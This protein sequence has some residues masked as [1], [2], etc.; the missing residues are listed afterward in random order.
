[1]LYAFLRPLLFTLEPERAHRLALGLLRLL[2]VLS[3]QKPLSEKRLAQ[4]LWGLHFPNPVGLAAGLDKDAEAPLVWSA[5]GFG[6]AELG[7][8]TARAQEGNSRPRVFRLRKDGAIINRMGFPSLGAE[9]VSRRLCQL[10]RRPVVPLG[11]N[12][13]KSR[14]VPLEEAEADLEQSLELLFPFA[15][16]FVLNV[17]SP[18]TPGL[19]KL[20]QPERLGRLLEALKKQNRTLSSEGGLAPRPLLVKV[21]SD[22]EPEALLEMARVARAAGADGFVAANTTVAR[23]PLC[24]GISEEGG[25]SGKPLARRA[26]ETVRS[27]FLATEGR[28]PI[29]GVGGIFSAEDAYEKILAGASLVELYTGLVYQGPFLPRRIVRGLSRLLE[30]DGFGHLEEAVG[31][32]A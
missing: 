10:S 21:S 20:E 3:W 32:R 28:L 31:K 22:L 16:Y 17:S 14:M 11:L 23:P 30:R 7:T 6:F 29:V 25:L 27:L 18:N 1:M 24:S 9:A 26:T 13:G 2:Q 19:R 15:D 8:V 5:L 4:N 12:I